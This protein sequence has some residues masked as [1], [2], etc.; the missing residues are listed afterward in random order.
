MP[1]RNQEVP[2][3]SR[4]MGLVSLF[5]VIGLSAFELNEPHDPI[6]CFEPHKSAPINRQHD[7]LSVLFQLSCFWPSVQVSNLEIVAFVPHCLL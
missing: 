1:D 3:G 2:L 7:G 6:K 4:T 5:E